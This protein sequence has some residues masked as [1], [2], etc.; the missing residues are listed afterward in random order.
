MILQ[1]VYSES[2]PQEI[3]I[4]QEIKFLLE[5]F[6][7]LWSHSQVRL[8]NWLYQGKTISKQIDSRSYQN[9]I[10]SDFIFYFFLFF[11]LYLFIYLMDFYNCAHSWSFEANTDMHSHTTNFQQITSMASK[12]KINRIFF[13]S[14]LVLSFHLHRLYRQSSIWFNWNPTV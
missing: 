13:L 14:I 5:T 9:T 7:P 10:V 1:D 4:H 3:W 8:A 6:T 12:R 11:V 2:R